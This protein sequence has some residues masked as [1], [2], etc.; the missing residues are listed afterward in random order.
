MICFSAFLLA[1]G[2]AS[3]LPSQHLHPLSDEFIKEINSKQSTWIAGR[4]FEVEEYELFKVLATGAK[5]SSVPIVHKKIHNED[6]N[7]PESFDSREAWPQCADIISL[8]RDQ[9]R[10]GSCWVSYILKFRK[11]LFDFNNNL[12][13][14]RHLQL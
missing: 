10:C 2:L 14:F 13:Y 9:S 1:V 8:I 5:R 12:F 4:N 11:K 6:D 3:A 7:I